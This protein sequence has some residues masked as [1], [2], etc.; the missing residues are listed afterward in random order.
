MKLFKKK[1]EIISIGLMIIRNSRLYSTA[2]R[3][4]K[5]VLIGIIKIKLM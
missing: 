2:L 4:F 5:I 3:Q 1:T